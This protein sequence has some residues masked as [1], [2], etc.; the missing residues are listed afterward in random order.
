[1]RNPVSVLL[2]FISHHVSRALLALYVGSLLAGCGGGASGQSLPPASVIIGTVTGMNCPGN[3]A[4]CVAQPSSTAKATRPFTCAADAMTCVEVTSTASAAQALVPLTFGQPFKASDLGKDQS[5]TARDSSGKDLPLQMDAISSHNDGSRRFAV[6][7]TE[8]SDLQSG[9]RRIV[10]LYRGQPTTAP[11]AAVDVSGFDMQLNATLYSPQITQ[12]VFGNRSGTTPGKPFLEGEQI[13]LVLNGPASETFSH[14]V[15]ANEAG[16]GFQTLTLIAEAFN[17]LINAQSTA[18]RAYKQGEGGGYERLWITTQSNEAGAFSVQFK[19]AGTGVLASSP[20]Q[21]YASPRPLQAKPRTEL[22]KM[23]AQPASA[24]LSGPVTTEYTVVSPFIDA[25]TGLAHPQLT[26]R[27]H[28]R[29]Y[30]GN[31]LI[32]T[33]VVMENDWAYNPNP[34]NLTYKLDILQGGRTALSQPVFTHYHHARWHRVMWSAAAPQVTLRHSMPYFMASRITWNYDLGVQ[35]PESVLVAEASDLSKQDT[36]PMGAAMILPYFP[37]TGGRSDIGPLPR[38]TALYLVT[39]DDRAR[40]SMMANADAA[41]SVPIHYR[42]AIS[43]QPLDLDRH[44]GVALGSGKSSTADSLPSVINGSTPWTPDV[45]HQ[46]S[47]AFIPYILTGDAYYLDEVLFWAG[48][49]MGSINPGYRGFT[50][51]LIYPE[52]LRGQAWAMRS[53]GEAVFSLPDNHPQKNYFKTRLQNN[54]QWFVDRF[55]NNKDATKT[56]PI[57]AIEKADAPGMN[58]PWQQDFLSIVMSLLA[59]NGE[60]LAGDFL[61]W[62]AKFTVGRYMHESAGFCMAKAPGYYIK[63]RDSSGSFIS[64]WSEL[65]KANWPDIPACTASLVIDGAPKSAAGYAAYSR[66][67]LA[68]ASNA[69]LPEA[70]QAF[71]AWQQMTP[72]I[73]GAFGSDP[74]WAIV[75]RPAQ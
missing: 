62:S 50:A 41:G 20:L 26:A 16:G 39:Q 38:W 10:N 73:A 11:A 18:Y 65:F 32:R 53:I 5:L 30:P 68:A 24:R 49:N 66:A 6:L 9:E 1:M 23:L 33:D 74:T 72:D 69:G 64:T 25:S 37:T 46:A 59:E 14:T 7:S 47:F 40:A 2:A 22:L 51:G 75:P 48:W 71:T 34:G 29:F 3:A 61:R 15:T 17:A 19:Y 28:V 27:L 57:G 70:R 56:S 8:L 31:H 52:Q 44:P 60:P 21:A 42:D 67:M 55:P 35:V 36:G 12:V 45:S 58:G 63:I 54:L 4:S 43:D 13:T